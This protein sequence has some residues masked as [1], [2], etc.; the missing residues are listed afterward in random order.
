LGLAFLCIAALGAAACVQTNN[1]VGWA[2]PA[3]SDTIVVAA[4]DRGELSAFETADVERDDAQPLWKF[5][6]GDEEPELD[7]RAIYGTP[8]IV[9]D[10]VYF[11]AYSG[12][13]WALSLEDGSV[14]WSFDTQAPI[15]AG[16]AASDTA[17]YAA[18]DDGS[19]IALD[20]D[21]GDELRRFSAG[22]SVWGAPLVADDT[23]YVASV[24]GKLYAL[25]ASTFE[26]EWDEPYQTG[27]G[28]I[29]DP[30]LA[31]GIVLSGGLDRA[32]HAVD[33]ATGAERW[34]FK[35]DNWFWGRP[36]VLDGT[37][38]APNLDSRVY[39]LDLD[40]GD[41]AMPA[42][43][44]EQPVRS[45]P[46]L[47]GDALVIIDRSGN[48]YGVSV[49]LSEQLWDAPA[50]LD[51]TVLSDALVLDGKVLISSD[52]GGLFSVDPEAGT[53]VQVVAP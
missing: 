25:N 26:P 10:R 11:G 16:L 19:L 30:V 22:D 48:V 49:D 46:V 51:K 13:V 8:L 28:L 50:F 29:S 4:T 44:A 42:F 31:D 24:N 6:S 43:E 34:T 2:G 14:E 18:N 45:A 12:E 38:Y 39:A 41:E 40:S 3:A 35:S 5:P 9:G 37:V 15:I 20:P 53:F 23:V 36:L 7:L 52:G 27:H 47:A 1:P 33:A 21:S 32:M 17:L